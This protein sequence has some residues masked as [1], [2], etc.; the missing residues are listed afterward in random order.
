MIIGILGLSLREFNDYCRLRGFKRIS[1]TEYID[2]IDT[3]ICIDNI[4]RVHGREFNIIRD[5]DPLRLAVTQRMRD[6]KNYH[7]GNASGLF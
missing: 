4:M 1:E 6:E 7:F 2:S 3:Y 5:F